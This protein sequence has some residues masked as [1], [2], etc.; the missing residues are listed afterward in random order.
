[1]HSKHQGS[2]ASEG[3][4][5]RELRRQNRIEFSF[6]KLFPSINEVKIS[7]K[8]LG[9]QGSGVLEGIKRQEN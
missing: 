5:V 4:R 6:K 9:H 2:K 8:N 7:R 3:L 1:M